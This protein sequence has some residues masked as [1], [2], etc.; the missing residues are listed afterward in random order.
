MD[1][2][3]RTHQ[4]QNRL[5][6][7]GLLA[8]GE[9]PVDPRDL[10]EDWHPDFGFELV[11]LTLTTK[12]DGSLI[13]HGDRGANLVDRDD[14]QFDLS[15]EVSDAT[16]STAGTTAAAA[17][18]TGTTEATTTAASGTGEGRLLEFNKL[19]RIEPAGELDICLLYTSDA[20]DE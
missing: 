12:H 20:A 15:S 19:G 14:G 1:D 3:L 11:D 7:L 6:T 9:E 16:A 17:A 10:G 4:E 2:D 18:T 13:R 5:F 8:V